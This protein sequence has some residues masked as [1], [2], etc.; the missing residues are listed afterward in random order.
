MNIDNKLFDWIGGKKWLS[1]KLNNKFDYILNSNSL[2]YYVEPFCGS[3]GSLIGSIETLKKYKIEKIYLN[4]INNNVI[5]TYRLVKERPIDLF[6]EFNRIESEHLKLMPDECFTLNKTKDK[7]RLKSLMENSKNYYI[8]MRDYFNL[9]KNDNNK[10][11]ESSSIFLFLMAR[12]FNGIYRE[13]SK[14]FFNSPY[15]W[16][17]KIINV[18]NKR[19]VIMSF[20]KFFNE[21]NIE[22]YNL[23]YDDFLD[24][25]EDIKNDTLFYFDPPY[26][27][28]DIKENNYNKDSFGLEQQKKLL[29]YINGYDNIV[30]SNHDLD[31]FKD[32]F[33]EPKFSKE[34]VYRKNNMA[35][36][37]KSRNN[38][39]A[40]ILAYTNKKREL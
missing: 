29:N 39:V 7:V 24:K 3:L 13:N 26:L 38:D 9:I 17:N 32:F 14:G 15:G 21:M 36:D 19:K 6:N 5:N 30:Y 8:K 11:L 27:N 34:T 25:F 37:S 12:S 33:I 22:F 1:D 4:D 10:Q 2:K 20:N 28:K 18:D 35:P 16:T 40:E 31:I 23:S